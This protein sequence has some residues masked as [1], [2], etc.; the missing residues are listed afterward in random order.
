MLL[1]VQENK[2]KRIQDGKAN[3]EMMMTKKS[4]LPK[5]DDAADVETDEGQ[6]KVLMILPYTTTYNACHLHL[7]Y[8]V[9]V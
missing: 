5:Q 2:E 7:V 3:Q 9:V 4:I 8:L 6:G 1:S